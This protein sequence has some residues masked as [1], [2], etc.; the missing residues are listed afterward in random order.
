MKNYIRKSL[1]LGT[2]LATNTLYSDNLQKAIDRQFRADMNYALRHSDN[3]DSRIEQL[4]KQAKAITNAHAKDVAILRSKL[5]KYQDYE[6][7]KIENQKAK[8]VL[9]R[10]EHKV[11]TLTKILDEE[12]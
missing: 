6:A 10:C 11:N 4:K 8:L 12:D 1:I 5:E 3:P 9:K 7:L 2:L